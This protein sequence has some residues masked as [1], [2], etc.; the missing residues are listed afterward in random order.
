M[1]TTA[2]KRVEG[3]YDVQKVPFGTVYRWHLEHYSVLE[4]G[5]DHETS[6]AEATT[7][8]RVAD[9]ALHPWRYVE[10]R[11]DAGLPC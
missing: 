2:K 11:E 4:C 7:A 5:A 6:A 1:L 8:R 10:D 9:E 3:H